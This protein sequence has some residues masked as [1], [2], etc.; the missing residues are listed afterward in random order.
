MR[1]IVIFAKCTKRRKRRE[2]FESL[3]ACT[4]SRE[5]LKEFSSN[6]EC[7]LLTVEDTYTVNLVPF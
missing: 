3:I 6:L 7:G 5:W 1:V 2:F 4:I